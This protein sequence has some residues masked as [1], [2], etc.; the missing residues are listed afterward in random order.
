MRWMAV[1]V[2]SVDGVSTC[3]VDVGRHGDGKPV[4]R[5]LAVV[6]DDVGVMLMV[7]MAVRGRGG[8]CWWLEWW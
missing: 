2:E 1:I 7:L 6:V 5:W 4:M 3:V 8:Y